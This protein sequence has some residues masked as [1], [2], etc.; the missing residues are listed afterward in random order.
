[1][2][3]PEETHDMLSQNQDAFL[4][5]QL[6]VYSEFIEILTA[7]RTEI[8]NSF[9]RPYE[10]RRQSNSLAEYINSRLRILISVSNGLSN[11]ERFRA[12][13][14]YALNKFVCY[15]ISSH[16][17]SNKRQGKPRGKYSKHPE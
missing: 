17:T 3:S 9:C 10:D 7:W 1:M 5:A 13:A 12:R 6:P 2:Y 15:S 4:T 16:L 8:I 14:I 11:F